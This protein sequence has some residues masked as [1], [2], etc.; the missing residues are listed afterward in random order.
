[1][2]SVEPGTG[3][4][5]PWDAAAATPSPSLADGLEGQDVAHAGARVSIAG[6]AAFLFAVPFALLVMLI[7][8]ESEFVERL[9]R[10]ASDALHELVSGH[11]GG[12]N[13][14]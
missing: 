2:S 8:S 13:S 14:A 7:T 9:D 1:M 6:L 12:H 10:R 4:R 5:Q 3:A 11:R